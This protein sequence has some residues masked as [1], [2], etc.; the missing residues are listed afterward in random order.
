MNFDIKRQGNTIFIYLEGRLL[1]N[2]NDA[3]LLDQVEGLQNEGVKYAAIDLSKL[4]MINSAGIGL[5]MRILVKFRNKSGEVCLIQPSKNIRDLLIITK[6][7]A[8]FTIV[9]HEE[10]ALKRLKEE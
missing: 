3:L 4:E 9:E 10:D 6:L 7:V 5:L 1:G 2:H 8:I